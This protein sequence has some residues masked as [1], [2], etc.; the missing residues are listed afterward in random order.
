M[1]VQ[2]EQVK[3]RVLH[4]LLGAGED[5]LDFSQDVEVRDRQPYRCS[6]WHLHIVNEFRSSESVH[7]CVIFNAFMNL[8]FVVMNNKFRGCVSVNVQVCQ[9]HGGSINRDLVWVWRKHCCVEIRTVK[10]RIVPALLG[11]TDSIIFVTQLNFLD[12]ICLLQRAC[13]GCDATHYLSTCSTKT[14]KRAFSSQTQKHYFYHH[15]EQETKT[16]LWSYCVGLCP[17]VCR[18]GGQ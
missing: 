16:R 14:N 18:A 5:A 12:W 8:S 13:Q 9:Q 4:T 10:C 11:L 3:Q 7:V 1:L 15:P 17:S 6:W 2:W